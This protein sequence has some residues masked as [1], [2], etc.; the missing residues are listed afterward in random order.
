MKNEKSP[1]EQDMIQTK[2]KAQINTEFLGIKLCEHTNIL[3]TVK[4]TS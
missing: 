2:L 3:Q 4:E 1:R